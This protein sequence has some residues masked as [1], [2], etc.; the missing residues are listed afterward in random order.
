MDESHCGSEAGLEQYV[1]P[2]E[3]IYLAQENRKLFAF[4]TSGN[5][6]VLRMIYGFLLAN[7]QS[8]ACYR[9]LLDCVAYADHLLAYHDQALV[10]KVR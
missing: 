9:A 2:I 7:P 10:D 6:R 8:E 4:C 3:K 5:E 1:L